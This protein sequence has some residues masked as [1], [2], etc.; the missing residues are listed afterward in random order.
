MFCLFC[1]P[2]TAAGAIGNPPEIDWAYYKERLPSVDI[3][4]LKTNYEAFQA[5][6]PS[7]AYDP[8]ADIAA[9]TKQVK[10]GLLF[11]A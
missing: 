3:D 1:G 9:A 11:P 2:Q 5:A 6:V 8:T 4:A 7:I 10:P